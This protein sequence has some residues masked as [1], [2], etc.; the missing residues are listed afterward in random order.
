MVPELSPEHGEVH[1]AARAYHHHGL[2]AG[3]RS[4]RDR[5]AVAKRIQHTERSI[6]D[7]L[8]HVSSMID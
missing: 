7:E 5:Q 4:G 8:F 3:G 6:A 2:S 1:P